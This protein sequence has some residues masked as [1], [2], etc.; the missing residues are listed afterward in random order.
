MGGRGTGRR[1]VERYHTRSRKAGE[2]AAACYNESRSPRRLR[3]VGKEVC[4][5][6]AGL[7][8]LCLKIAVAAVT[9]LLLASLTALYFKRYKLHGR[10]NIVF[11][12]LTVAA[13]VGLEVIVRLL[14]PDL[15][16]A[17]RG[18]RLTVHLC[19]AVPAAVLMPLMLFTGLKGR[20]AVHVG[21]SYLFGVLWAGTFITGIF[22]LEAP[23][24]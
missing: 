1:A 21:L 17:I 4:V 11:F 16:D 14:R 7:V 2:A 15:F 22:F 18:P 19:F 6:T 12:G 8:I 10:L 20:S 3:T 5:L 24:P 23:G 13:L 9:V